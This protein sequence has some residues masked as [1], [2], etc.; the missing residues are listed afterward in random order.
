MQR[1][2]IA[3]A[4]A[5]QPEVMLFDEPT[6]ALYPEMVGEVLSVMQRLAQEGM[7][8]VIVTHEWDLPKRLATAFFSWTKGSLWKRG[9]LLKY[10][11][12]RKIR[13]QSIFWQK[14]YDLF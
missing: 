8:M 7:T 5:M 2:A 3:R 1:I 10:L 11:M 12:H 9:L 13:G 6:S 4:L 14:S